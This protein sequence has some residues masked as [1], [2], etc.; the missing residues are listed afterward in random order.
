MDE[1]QRWFG[2]N[3]CDIC[4]AEIKDVLFDAQRRDLPEW[5]TMCQKCYDVYGTPIAWGSGQ[6]YEEE[7]G[8]FYLTAGGQPEEEDAGDGENKITVSPDM[9]V[10][11]LLRMLLKKQV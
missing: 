6:K 5:A 8:V 10:N 3:I 7:D 9:D 4:G 2:E 1:R 11:D